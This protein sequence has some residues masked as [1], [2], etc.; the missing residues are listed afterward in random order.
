[1]SCSAFHLCIYTST[2][3]CMSPPHTATHTQ[4]PQCIRVPH[5]YLHIQ[6]HITHTS[7]Q[8]NT[9]IHTYI[10]T[11]L[12]T[13]TNTSVHTYM[14][15]YTHAHV[16]HTYRYTQLHMTH[17]CTH[18]EP[19]RESILKVASEKHQGTYKDKSIIIT[20]VF[21]TETLKAKRA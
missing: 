19:K 7:T 17:I 1:M 2:L 8:T 15:T 10:D 11:H 12:N 14:Y 4:I 18:T 20:T 21:S 9:A 3:T 13:Y 16:I 6:V 5:M